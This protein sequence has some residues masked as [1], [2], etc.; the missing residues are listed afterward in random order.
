[1]ACHLFGTKSSYKPVLAYWQI[2]RWWAYFREILF[3][4]SYQ[5]QTHYQPTALYHHIGSRTPSQ[6][7]KRRLSVR[8]RKVSKPRD[9]YLELSD[10]SEIWQALRQ[11]CCRCA[12]QIS[13]RYDNLKYQSR[14]FETIRD[15]TKRRIFGYWD[16]AQDNATI[17]FQRVC[18][19]T[20]SWTNSF[21]L[22]N[23]NMYIIHMHYVFHACIKV[24]SNLQCPMHVYSI[25]ILFASIHH[26]CT[27]SNGVF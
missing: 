21:S 22:I 5:W 8:S 25:C 9:L 11:Q 12:C 19:N 3:E 14:G 15:L 18:S 13:K 7:P 16:G 6:Y 26:R 24:V 2:R 27:S 20:F 23:T 10:R 1:M 4:N 17:I